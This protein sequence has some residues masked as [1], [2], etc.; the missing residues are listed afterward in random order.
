MNNKTHIQL[1]ISRNLLRIRT[2]K[3]CSQ[4]EIANILRIKQPSYNRIESGRTRISADQLAVLAIY[5]EISVDYFFK[6]ERD[7]ACKS[8]LIHDNLN[9][10]VLNT[11][12][13]IKNKLN[14][15]S[16]IYYEKNSDYEKS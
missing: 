8:N 11:I 5:Y 14:N 2:Q 16:E 10:E 4:G 12:K 9:R 7:E 3:R 15:L 1:L 13:E 6:D